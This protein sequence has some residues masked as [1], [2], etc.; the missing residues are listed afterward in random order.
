M[1]DGAAAMTLSAP[2]ANVAVPSAGTDGM[3]GMHWYRTVVDTALD[4]IVTCDAD[5]S[6]AFVNPA[7]VQLFGHP[8]A[9]A[10]G[11]Q[12]RE[13][14]APQ[15]RASCM[16][17]Q[18]AGQGQF[19][20]VGLRANGDVFPMWVAMGRTMLPDGVLITAIVRDLSA[21]R[22]AQLDAQR[23]LEALAHVTRQAAI[24]DLASGLAHEVAQPL[25]AILSYAGAC[26]RMLADEHMPLQVAAG[27]IEQILRQARRAV[28][29]MQRLR[30]FMRPNDAERRPGLLNAGVNDVLELLA[31]EIVRLEV[32]VDLDL[33][34][35]L[36]ALMMDRV[37]IEQVIFNLVRNAL[38]A[39]S[40]VPPVRRLLRIRTR[41]DADLRVV[42]LTV[43]DRGPGLPDG[44]PEQ[45]F[46]PYF[47]TKP[48]GLGIG[49]SIC[50]CIVESH[51]G[52][53]WA[54]RHE[55]D[56]ASFH[57]TLPLDRGEST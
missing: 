54:V 7:A 24:S 50:R 29:L 52:S 56:G 49:L 6:I 11:L 31:H 19:E 35:D 22:A 4:G 53:L 25:T 43:G 27:S 9:A 10:A 40:Q 26:R 3:R 20:A 28:D 57:F 30:N 34:P 48:R 17:T 47:T 36:P 21:L 46:E 42:T 33:Q 1:R 23:H 8:A 14:F 13:L 39:L 55:G 5:G 37:A 51:G 41:L 32:V 2:R 45:L 44:D 12:L 38:D 15:S 18:E 16:R